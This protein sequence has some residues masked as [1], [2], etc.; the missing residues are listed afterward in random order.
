V[1]QE[2]ELKGNID[3]KKRES[4]FNWAVKQNPKDLASSIVSLFTKEQIDKLIE[5]EKIDLEL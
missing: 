3:F 4:V 5:L 2:K 1:N